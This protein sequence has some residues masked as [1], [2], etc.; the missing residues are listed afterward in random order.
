MLAA[1]IS[2]GDDEAE[3]LALAAMAAHA[4]PDHAR[5]LAERGG[6]RL[7][8]GLQPAL[9]EVAGRANTAPINRIKPI[10]KI[11]T[12][13]SPCIW[14]VKPPPEVFELALC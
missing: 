11:A 7:T 13:R 3:E 10:A 12:R 5:S 14:A 1:P 6:T 2:P 9:A 8:M 4:E